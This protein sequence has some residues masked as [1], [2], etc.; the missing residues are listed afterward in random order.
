MLKTLQ[1]F[2]VRI[3]SVA[4]LTAPLTAFAQWSTGNYSSSGLA[5]T[6]LTL[7]ITNAMNWLL[8]IL[9][10]IAIIGFVIS[11]ILYLTAYGEEAQIEKAKK[12]M[13]YSIVGILVAL[14]GFIAVKAISGFLGGGNTF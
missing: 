4:A 6:S 1:K 11:G 2:G 3:V 8:Y 13:L 7:L 12:A 14:I 9:G 10:F 5:G